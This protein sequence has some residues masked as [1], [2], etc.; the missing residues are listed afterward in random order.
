LVHGL[1]SVQ[2]GWTIGEIQ[3]VLFLRNLAEHD[4]FEQ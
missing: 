1:P 4:G 3:R 2:S